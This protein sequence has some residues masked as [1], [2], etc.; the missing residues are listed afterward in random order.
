MSSAVLPSKQ[1]TSRG[2]RPRPT[3]ARQ[4]PAG[5]PGVPRSSRP[6]A[7]CPHPRSRSRAWSSRTGTGSGPRGRWRG[8]SRPRRPGRGSHM[9]G[10]GRATGTS[11]AA[12]HGRRRARPRPAPG[13][14]S[15]CSSVS[16]WS[17]LMAFSNANGWCSRGWSAAGDGCRRSRSSG[18]P[19]GALRPGSAR[20]SDRRTRSSAWPRMTRPS[21][22]PSTRSSMCV[23]GAAIGVEHEIVGHGAAQGVRHPQ[24]PVYEVGVLAVVHRPA[25]HARGV[26]IT[27]HGQEQS[28][29][30]GSQIGDVA[31][32]DGVEASLVPL[33]PGVISEFVGGRILD[34]RHR[35]EHARADT[36]QALP[37]H[38]RRN[39]LAVDHH[40]LGGEFA[41]DPRGTV[42]V[43]GGT[44]LLAHRA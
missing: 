41:G 36:L 17:H 14:P 39:R 38:R 2:T 29:L 16:A 19:R 34:G 25:Q 13:R 40:T 20:N 24:S 1:A 11:C 23:L 6:C 18:R 42:D 15:L 28:A 31:G 22:C 33:P 26:A 8:Q 43:V 9:P 21:R 10:S 27:D 32:P 3:A 35:G 7:G 30:S 4:A 37:A 44:E 5:R 12:K